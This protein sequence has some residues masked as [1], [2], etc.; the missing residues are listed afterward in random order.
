MSKFD[1]D[2][3]PIKA[4]AYQ[5]GQ[6]LSQASESDLAACLVMLRDELSRLEHEQAKRAHLRTSADSFF[7]SKSS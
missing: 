3:H 1:D 7:K 2:G 4:A 5:L 6:D